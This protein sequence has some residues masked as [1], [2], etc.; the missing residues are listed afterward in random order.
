MFL[1]FEVGNYKSIRD[2]ACLSMSSVNY[3]KENELQLIDPGLPGMAGARFVSAA[4]IYGANASGKST[5]ID[6]LETMREIV[7]GS[8]FIAPTSELDHRPFLLDDA[9][10][11]APTSFL[12]SFSSD[13]VRYEYG[14]TYDARTVFEEFLRS[15]PK[16]RRR[17]VF[18]RSSDSSVDGNTHTAITTNGDMKLPSGIEELLNDNSLLLSFIANSP[19]Y[20]ASNVLEPV[21]GWFRDGLSIVR[22]GP[23]G[24]LDIGYSGEILDGAGTDGERMLI[25][26]L[27]READ[28]G[29]SDA[30][31]VKARLSDLI[32]A[33]G[34]PSDSAE[35][36]EMLDG[37]DGSE[38]LKT[39][40]FEHV[41]GDGSVDFNIGMESDGTFQLFDLSGHIAHALANGSVLF[42]D[43]IDASLH[44]ILVVELV[45]CF[46]DPE[47]NP[48]HA[49]LVFT[50]HNQI[51]LANGLL[52][53]DQIW[54]VEKADGATELFPLSDFQ[55]RQGENIERGYIGGA[56]A[57]I[58]A[59]EECF[60]MC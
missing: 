29:V 54:F 33:M 47:S 26:R 2:R 18:V 35:A 30:F 45:R 19:K 28:A 8:S 60:G 48:N 38:V 58:P 27:M 11:S 57:A 36:R 13:G 44:P 20:A 17:N 42:V 12:I 10:K 14:F 41:V 23:R 6:A 7:L 51:L 24:R 1:F 49:Q 21:F 43:E 32:E 53:R 40:E 34:V 39:V 5:L 4:A 37:R 3:Y 22:K 31:V 25:K 55:A 46:L 50:A 16:G 15:Y 56:Y 52:R 59:V 9:L